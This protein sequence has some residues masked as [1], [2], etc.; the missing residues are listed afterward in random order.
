M[1]ELTKTTEACRVPPSR[2]ASRRERSISTLVYNRLL[3]SNL[4]SK[5]LSLAHLLACFKRREC[6][7]TA[8]ELAARLLQAGY[9][10]DRSISQVLRAAGIV[11]RYVK[12][13]GQA[14]FERLISKR[15]IE[16]VRRQQELNRLSNEDRVKHQH[17]IEQHTYGR[18]FT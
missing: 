2:Q 5:P 16:F 10:Q 7:L 11:P 14:H 8:K 12:V 1:S 6:A 17:Q 3:D 9:V 13:R 15:R 18:S 4:M